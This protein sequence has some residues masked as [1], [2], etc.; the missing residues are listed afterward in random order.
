MIREK[1]KEFLKTGGILLTEIF[2]LKGL[3]GGTCHFSRSHMTSPQNQGNSNF[4]KL[5]QRLHSPQGFSATLQWAGAASGQPRFQSLPP[6]HGIFSVARMS[7]FLQESPVLAGRWAPCS[8]QTVQAQQNKDTGLTLP[9]STAG[10]QPQHIPEGTDLSLD[11]AGPRITQNTHP[12][13]IS[14]T[15]R[16]LR[17]ALCLITFFSWDTG[18]QT[19][20]TWAERPQKCPG[21]VRAPRI[22]SYVLNV[23]QNLGQINKQIW[24]KILHQVL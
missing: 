19:P 20:K 7:C 9:P 1:T 24:D 5:H 11:S 15:S 18:K 17:A 2:K 6:G 22:N 12:T 3:Q 8:N 16:T 13:K 21:K 4:T 14:S 23:V 10:L